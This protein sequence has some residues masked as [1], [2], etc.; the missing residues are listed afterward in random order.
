MQKTRKKINI[1]LIISVI[2]I[3]LGFG[4]SLAKYVIQENSIHIQ[5]AKK[6]YFNSSM[7]TENNTQY[8]LDDWNGKDN[9]N[10]TIDLKNYEDNLRFS[11]ED[12]SYNLL[13]TCDNNNITVTTSLDSE[14]SSLKGGQNST[15][16]INIQISPKINFSQGD[17]IELS[18]T[19]TATAPYEKTLSARFKIYVEEIIDYKTNLEQSQNSEYA[20]L[21]IETYDKDQNIVISYDNTKA[22]LDL[23]NDLF[24]QTEIVQNGTKSSVS[25][26][27]NKYSNYNI[28]FIKKDFDSELN[29]GTDI[30][31]SNN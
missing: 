22:I 11:K 20:N 27:I 29:L 6:F 15:E 17:F 23:N 31:V 3:I 5:T 9:Y 4:Y 18:V 2:I 21:Y 30:I 26:T 13:T 25:L 7:L 10:L 8:V 28:T 16:E 14:S 1:L 12:I 24:E 19:A